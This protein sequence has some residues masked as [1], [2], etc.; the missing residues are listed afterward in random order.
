MPSYDRRPAE[1]AEQVK[2][3][4]GAEGPVEELA[5]MEAGV[6]D[7]ATSR[8]QGLEAVRALA[9]ET[10]RQER[11]DEYQTALEWVRLAVGTSL[12]QLLEGIAEPSHRAWL[13]REK[14]MVEDD[15]FLGQLDGLKLGE[16]RDRMVALVR[17]LEEMIK[18]LDA[19][20]DTASD[21][22][23]RIE[24]LEREAARRMNDALRRAIDEALPLWQ[25]LGNQVGSFVDEVAK[26]PDQVNEA[27]VEVL[28][29][30]AGISREWAQLIPQIS[31]PGKD[32]FEA[33]KQLGIP[34]AE[35]AKALPFLTPDPGMWVGDTVKKL[36]GT[37]ITALLT[38]LGEARKTAVMYLIGGYAEAKQAFLSQLP[39]QGVI[40]STLSRTRHDVD[41][42]IQRNGVDAARKLT[43]EAR[44]GLDRW[45]ADQ[46]TDGL[47][48]DAATFAT[49]VKEGWAG[50][51][52]E[53][54]KTFETFVRENA[55]RFFG[56]VSS[57]TVE[58]VLHPSEWNG[59]RDGIL[60]LH[61]DERLRE[62]RA[63]AMAVEPG[64]LNAF[65]QI[66]GK[67]AGLPVPVQTALRQALDTEE[68]AFIAQVNA[69]AR[70]TTAVLDT[71]EQS[72]GADKV[73]ELFDRARLEAALRA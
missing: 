8:S 29:T 10:G 4:R 59:V 62:W 51:L 5:V 9:V 72:A 60:G 11:A 37:D 15:R 47:K 21:E 40:L 63:Q 67:V 18:A 56:P 1:L 69:S 61:L 71:A 26:L 70:E 35:F 16:A 68:R 3:L 57:D 23:K 28:V 20:W 30:K 19:K 46:P 33:A 50:L 45:A 64:C 14:A 17:N 53:M 2:A 66:S 22:D 41:D 34:A 55:G 25:K 36:L 43:D 27:L 12:Q 42:F 7:Y 39:N 48:A 31:S 52:A 65:K 24:D 58:A 13:V 49:A 32:S 38:I 6:T 44:A 54:E 73:K